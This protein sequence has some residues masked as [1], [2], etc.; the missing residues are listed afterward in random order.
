MTDMGLLLVSANSYFS[1]APLTN[2][3]QLNVLPDLQIEKTEKLA[4]FQAKSSDLLHVT[5]HRAFIGLDNKIMISENLKS[6]REVLETENRENIFWHMVEAT[7]GTLFVQEYGNPPTGIYRSGDNGE[8]WR[9]IVSSEKI[10]KK[11]RHFH[12]I[13]YDK[14]RDLLITT[15]GDG[16]LVKMALSHDHGDTWKPFYT[17]AYQCLPIVVLKD[18]IVFGMDSGI[19]HGIVTWDPL[20]NK[21]HCIHMTFVRKPAKIGNMQSSDLQF[22]NNDVWVMTTGGGS[23]LASHDLRNWSI[24]Y[25]GEEERFESH[26]ISNE[27]DGVVAIVMKNGAMIFDSKT[28]G[29]LDSVDVREYRAFVIRI[30]GVGYVV[31]RRIGYSPR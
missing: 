22:L 10:D 13:A 30:R 3:P 5:N 31:K 28:Q 8:T 1:K 15:L 24:L 6:W 25:R 21:W 11:A 23:I 27:K 7:D 4:E 9:K 12:N 19:S 14:Y 2:R 20:K 17:S 16:N 29:A 26:K 18:Q